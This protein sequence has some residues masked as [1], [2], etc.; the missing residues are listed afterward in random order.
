MRRIPRVLHSIVLPEGKNEEA[1]EVTRISGKSR[2][3][4]H[5]Q[6]IIAGEKAKQN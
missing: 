2:I 3:Q 1:A 4:Q 5:H 6:Y